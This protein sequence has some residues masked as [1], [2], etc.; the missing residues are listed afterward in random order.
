MMMGSYGQVPGVFPVR[1][2]GRVGDGVKGRH[3]RLPGGAPTRRPKVGGTVFVDPVE[4]GKGYVLTHTVTPPPGH[5]PR[6]PASPACLHRV[7]G[8]AQSDADRRR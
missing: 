5:E 6:R 8:R 2:F 7:G 3:A 1:S 4:G